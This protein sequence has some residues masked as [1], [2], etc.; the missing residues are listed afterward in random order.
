MLVYDDDHE[1]VNDNDVVIVARFT[2]NVLWLVGFSGVSI[3]NCLR[4]DVYLGSLLASFCWRFSPGGAGLDLLVLG[5]S[6]FLWLLRYFLHAPESLR[7]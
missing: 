5:L 2:S 4:D 7:Y 3:C 6:L 1:E